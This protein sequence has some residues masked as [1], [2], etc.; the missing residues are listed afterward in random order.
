MVVDAAKYLT[1]MKA[2]ATGEEAEMWGTMEEL[3][4]KKLWHQ[5]T[6]EIKQLIKLPSFKEG[7]KLI[8]FY[9]NF[10]AD[11]ESKLNP[12]SL[13]QIAMAAL[14]RF[15]EAEEALTFIRQIGEK[16]KENQEAFALTRILVAKI[17][18]HKYDKRRETQDIIEEVDKILS[19]VD[20]VSPVHS[21]FY[22]LCSDLYRI[23]GKHADFY[24][25]S[26]RYL[27]CTD[28]DELSRQ[29]QAKHAFFL[30]L[31]ALL[32]EG[33]FNFGELLAHKILESLRGTDN[34]WLI[35]LLFAFN[36][37]DVAKFRQLSP[38]WKTQADL[39]A[40]ETLLFEKVCLLCL[41]E[42]TFRRE[43][44][45]RK[46][47]FQDIAKETTLPVE[48]I[49]LLVIK[50]L[51]QTLVKGRIDQVDGSVHMTWVQPRVLDKNQV[52]VMMKKIDAW[53][54]SVS[55]MEMMIENEAGEILTY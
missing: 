46:I 53:G 22:L 44:T 49:E 41:M 4:T 35:D 9:N 16:T 3:Y 14:E 33:V 8:L 15:E 43:A 34:E 12:L 27:G 13:V 40:N 55:S 28:C 10:V 25:S 42:M 51:S 19:E 26:L 31:A 37:G 6:Q 24:R 18:L 38:K 36:A 21:H 1:E 54:Q 23:E 48:Q 17:K 5:L 30:S 11:F 45:Q 47:P 20:G 39:E 50:A 7:N 2:S 52:E 32:G 29:E